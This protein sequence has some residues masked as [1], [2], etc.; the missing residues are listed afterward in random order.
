MKWRATRAQA[1]P[2]HP[3]SSRLSPAHPDRALTLRE[4]G[5]ALLPSWEEREGGWQNLPFSTS[6]SLPQRNGNQKH[7]GH[8]QTGCCMGDR[9]N[10]VLCSHKHQEKKFC[11]IFSSNIITLYIFLYITTIYKK[12]LPESELWGHNL[13]ETL[14]YLSERPEVLLNKK[15]ILS[16][17][18]SVFHVL[19]SCLLRQNHT[20]LWLI[21]IQHL[22]Q[23]EN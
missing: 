4:Q 9:L 6:H 23:V 10:I 20:F 11:N 12:P 18:F 7:L 2:S 14:Q 16:A 15:Y 3:I 17:R 5:L 19:H 22:D 8:R 13:Q 1:T 21:R